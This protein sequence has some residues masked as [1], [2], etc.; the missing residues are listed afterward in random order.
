MKNMVITFKHHEE[1]LGNAVCVNGEPVIAPALTFSEYDLISFYPFFDHLRKRNFSIT[2]FANELLKL[3]K[4]EQEIIRWSAFY[5]YL[6]VR[7]CANYRKQISYDFHNTRM[8]RPSQFVEF[9]F[10]VSMHQK[11]T[12]EFASKHEA[13]LFGLIV[14][15]VSTSSIICILA[16]QTQF[17]KDVSA[18][19]NRSLEE[20]KI[21]ELKERIYAN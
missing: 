17:L 19:E 14:A 5:G 8:M 2:H 7:D 10:H 9:V 12:Y 6:L 1:S 13:Y 16:D 3:D 4:S 11:Q 18:M 15:V 20:R 21:E